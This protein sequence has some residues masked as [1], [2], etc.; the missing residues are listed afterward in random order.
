[1]RKDSLLVCR[2]RS[3]DRIDFLENNLA[4]GKAYTRGDIKEKI[5]SVLIL[6]IIMPS[7]S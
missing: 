5:A 7:S 6:A 4:I 1:M 2:S 3:E